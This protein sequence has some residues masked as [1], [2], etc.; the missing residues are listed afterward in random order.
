MNILLCIPCQ[1]WVRSRNRYRTLFTGC[2]KFEPHNRFHLFRSKIYNI[3][4]IDFFEWMAWTCWTR[5]AATSFLML[6]IFCNPHIIVVSCCCSLSAVDNREYSLRKFAQQSGLFIL[7]FL[8]GRVKEAPSILTAE[9]LSSNLPPTP[10]GSEGL[11]RWFLISLSKTK[12]SFSLKK[13]P[14]RHQ[15]T[16]IKKECL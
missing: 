11:F 7:S 4:Y 16:E 10:F 5:A 8:S 2:K 9:A 15:P 1:I 3:M 6:I 14:Q 12:Y 13:S